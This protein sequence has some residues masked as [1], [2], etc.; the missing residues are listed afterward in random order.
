MEKAFENKEEVKVL[1]FQN[2][3]EDLLLMLILVYVFARI[4]G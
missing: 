4:T 3:K 2:V 1:L